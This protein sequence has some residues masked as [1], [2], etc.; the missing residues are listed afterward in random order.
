[1][2]A[3]TNSVG[4][5]RVLVAD[6]DPLCLRL[7]ARLLRE[8]GHTGAL[9]PNGQKAL[10]LLAQKPFDVLLL[11][12]NMPVLDGLSTLTALRQSSGQRPIPV[13]LASG[14]DLRVDWDFYQRAGALGH[15][16]K[17]LSLEGLRQ[18]LTSLPRGCLSG[19]NACL[20]S[21]G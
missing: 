1:M 15:V 14:N 18:A 12:L 9:V 8:L 5:L 3:S 16:L 4:S 2:S 21:G 6:D 11:D 10:E 7:A 13:I 17:P 19:L 20:A